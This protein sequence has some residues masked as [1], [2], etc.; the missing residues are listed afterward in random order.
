MRSRSPEVCNRCADGGIVFLG[1][2]IYV[3]RVCDLA[4]CRRVH[5]VD[6]AGGE[7]FESWEP[8]GVTKRINSSMF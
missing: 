1:M 3:S 4:L 2:R 7:G 5:A 6:L 8:E